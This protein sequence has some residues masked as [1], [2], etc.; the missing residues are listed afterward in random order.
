MDDKQTQINDLKQKIQT[1]E[2]DLE[3][4]RQ[5]LFELAGEADSGAKVSGI[6]QTNTEGG[7]VVQGRFN[8]EN[9]IADSGK[10]YPVPANYA[11]KSKL[12]EGD[13]LKLTITKDGTFVFKQ[14]QPAGRDQV[15]ATLGF[16]DNAYHAEYSGKNYNLL[17][18][19]VTYHKA[20]PG[21]RIAIVIPS[22]GTGKWAAFENVLHNKEEEERFEENIKN[23]SREAAPVENPTE[24]LKPKSPLAD[25]EFEEKPEKLSNK[26]E[27]LIHTQEKVIEPL[28]KEPVKVEEKQPEKPDVLGAGD[29]E[30][31][32]PKHSAPQTAQPKQSQ[33]PAQAPVQPQTHPLEEK[34]AEA[35]IQ[36]SQPVQEMEI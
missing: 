16:S 28:P 21:D 2:R 5:A 3:A 12:V 8:G 33:A 18:A 4:A 32:P 6:S 25:V 26:K 17:Y 27:E 30:I 14:I 13:I 23:E 7:E 19:S 31:E 35:P 11:S 9:M 34:T 20:K 29:I 1:A 15:V 36:D 22:N 10:T 24:N